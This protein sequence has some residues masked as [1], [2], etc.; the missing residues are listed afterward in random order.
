MPDPATAGKTLRLEARAEGQ[1]RVL[2]ASG[3]LTEGECGEFLEALRREL[4]A[5][6][7]RL[8][9]DVDALLYLSSAG[10]GALVSAH[11]SF[12]NANRRLV[13]AGVNPKV[14]KL[15]ALTS[16]DKLIECADTVDEA[17]KRP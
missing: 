11:Q 9:L 7:P 4:K 8:V 3:Q 1:S 10:L 14:R 17:L 2:K 12:L 15:L 5:D 13:L 16:L 6:A